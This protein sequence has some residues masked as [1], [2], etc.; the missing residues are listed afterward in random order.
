MKYILIKEDK[1]Q[2]KINSM[3]NYNSLCRELKFEENQYCMN[4]SDFD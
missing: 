3:E 1:Q 4:D 2:I